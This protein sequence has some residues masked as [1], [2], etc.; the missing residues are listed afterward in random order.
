MD[1]DYN[2]KEKLKEYSALPFPRGMGCFSFKNGYSDSL[3][4][5]EI[6]DMSW[7]CLTKAARIE[8]GAE[9]RGW[10]ARRP[11]RVRR[12]DYSFSDPFTGLILL[13]WT[14]LRVTI[15]LATRAFPFSRLSKTSDSPTRI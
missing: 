6:A 5:F 1:K 14:A 4:F 12:N 7:P 3:T 2:T 11:P 8:V 10:E 9:D 15:A 13:R